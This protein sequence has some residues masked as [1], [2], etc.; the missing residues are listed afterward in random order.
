MNAERQKG[1]VRK[2]RGLLAKASD[3]S[4]PEAEQDTYRNHARR[5]M[6]QYCIERVDEVPAEDFVIEENFQ[7]FSGLIIDRSLYPV[8]PHILLPIAKYCGCFVMCNHIEKGRIEVFVG[9]KPNI[10]MAQYTSNVVLKQG[11]D[12]YRRLYKMHRSIT[13]GQSF[14]SG[15][16]LGIEKK[17][18]IEKMSSERGIVLYDRAKDYLQKRTGGRTRNSAIDLS[19]HDMTKHGEEVGENVRVWKPVTG[20]GGGF[21]E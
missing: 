21:L 9:F 19:R 17:F 6:E 1:L 20:S 7:P 16:A 4:I 8:L 10:E 5:L 3:P 2:I 12:E 18:K 15:F 13:F 11:Q 14:W